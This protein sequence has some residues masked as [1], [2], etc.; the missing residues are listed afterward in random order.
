MEIPQELP[1][2]LQ[3]ARAGYTEARAKLL[4]FCRTY[5]WNLKGC[6]IPWNCQ[7]KVDADDLIQETLSQFDKEL[8]QGDDLNPDEMLALLRCIWKRTWRHLLQLY[9]TNKRAVG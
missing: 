1:Q 4:T 3:K 6:P 8:D 5:L 7:A 2:R 9:G